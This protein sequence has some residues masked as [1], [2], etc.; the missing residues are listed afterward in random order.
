VCTHQV[1][2]LF[3]VKLRYGRHLESMKSYQKSESVNRCTFTWRTIMLN[4]IPIRLET[5]EPWASLEESRPK[6]SKKNNKMIVA[7]WDQFLIWKQN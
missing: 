4:F 7:I 1:A 2:A 5:T 6:K 3:C